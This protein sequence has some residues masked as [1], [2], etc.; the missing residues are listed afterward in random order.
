MIYKHKYFI[1]DPDV[2]K[3]FDENNKELKITGNSFRVLVFLC[4]HGP[5]TVT[6]ISDILDRAKDYDEDHI[7]QYRYKINT[8][9]GKNIIKYENK[10]YFIDGETEK[11]SNEDELT[12]NKN[13]RNTDLLQSK[14]YNKAID[15]K[16][17]KKIFISLGIIFISAMAVYYLYQGFNPKCDIKGNINA[18]GEKI[19]HTSNCSLYNETIINETKGEKWFCSERE[20]L[21]AGWRKALNCNK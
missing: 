2:R 1:L 20:A 3:I 21:L 10:I 15:M 5:A 14:I 6:D 19:Y 9:I 17:Y 11:M 18:N 12:L 16:N 4:E 8:I 7:R 13:N